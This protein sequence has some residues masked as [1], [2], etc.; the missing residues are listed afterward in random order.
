MVW[1][2]LSFNSDNTDI[3][4]DLTCPLNARTATPFFV[5]QPRKKLLVCAEERDS[6]EFT[7]AT[8]LSSTFSVGFSMNQLKRMLCFENPRNILRLAGGQKAREERRLL[9]FTKFYSVVFNGI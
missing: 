6:E 7:I 3:Y 1:G 4:F 9:K 8:E 5:F 2:A